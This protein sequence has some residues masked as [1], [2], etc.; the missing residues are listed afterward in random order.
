MNTMDF[1]I[2]SNRFQ[3]TILL[4]IPLFKSKNLRGM[5]QLRGFFSIKKIANLG[6]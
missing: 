5:K 2:K 6:F 4:V 1:E 3:V